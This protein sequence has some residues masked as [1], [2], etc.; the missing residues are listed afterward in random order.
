MAKVRAKFRCDTITHMIASMWDADA[1]LSI[2]TPVRTIK[3]S[4]VYAN[5]DPNHENTKFWPATPS[6]SVELGIIN[7][8]AADQFEV[9]KEYYV[10]FTAAD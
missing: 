5:G 3:L 8:A 4:P 10:D 9:G 1:K 2:P 6:G 7:A